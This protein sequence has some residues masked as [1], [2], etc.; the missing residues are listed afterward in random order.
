MK[1]LL[2]TVVITITMAASLTAQTGDVSDSTKTINMVR[3]F[4]GYSFYQN[5]E[6]LTMSQLD[7]I[8]KISPIAYTVF[9]QARSTHKWSAFF[10]ITGGVLIGI[11]IGTV[12][13]GGEPIWALAGAGAAS[14]II[15][16][17][18]TRKYN[19]QMENAIDVYNAGL[20]AAPTSRI[21]H[22]LIFGNTTAGWGLC[23]RF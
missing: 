12:I 11:P 8:V 22:Q 17:P 10:S 16:I 3:E 1:A 7:S 18:I 23:Y 4:G 5:N 14:I 21:K 13:V 2:L 20:G 19:H 15:S 9:K 6:P